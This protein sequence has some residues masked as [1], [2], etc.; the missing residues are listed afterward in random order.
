MDKFLII[1]AGSSS[2]KFGLFDDENT[3]AKGI[4][5]RIPFDPEGTIENLKNNEK[6]NEK[7]QA[8]NYEESLKWIF[9]KITELK[10]I[11]DLSE[12]KYV[13]HRVVHGGNISKTVEI[14]EE[15]I[16]IIEQNIELAPLHNPPNLEGIK[17]AMKLL[18]VKHFAIFDTAFHQSMGNRHY[19]Y[20]LPLEITKKYRRYG[21]HGTSHKYVYNRA[22]EILNNERLNAITTHLG[23]GCSIAAISNNNVIHTTMGLT[24]LEGLMMGTRSGDVDPGIVIK[25][26]DQDVDNLLNKQ[27]GFKGIT[28]KS[29][30]R[31][32]IEMA[33]LENCS[34]KELE[35]LSKRNNFDLEKKEEIGKLALLMFSDRVVK[36]LSWY[37]NLVE[38]EAVIFTGGIGEHS[39]QM[40]K[41][42]GE[43]L[44]A[45]IDNEKNRSNETFIG[46]VGN[47]KIMVIPTNEELQM[48]REIKETMNLN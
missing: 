22:K 38:P 15:I 46:N 28:G 5:E 9:K 35:E 6:I 7:I 39:W 3:I 21:F 2:I 26:K 13:G 43:G 34:P 41:L 36:Y 17:A 37:I 45:K 14:N 48:V 20:P 23:N 12:I 31:E 32:I 47:T 24:P 25:L 10:I 29:D 18:K 19:L 27:S 1:N 30:L 16:R 44:H 42:I 33:E 11:E 8:E 4:V 40:R